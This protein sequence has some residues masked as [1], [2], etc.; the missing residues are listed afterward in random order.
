MATKRIFVVFVLPVI[1]SVIF[2]S[3]VMYGILEKPDRELNMWRI[4]STDEISTHSND[5]SKIQIIGLSS[6][7]STSDPV[8][9]QVNVADSSFSCGDIYITIHSSNTNEVIVQNGFFS[10]CFNANNGILPIDDAFS[11]VIDTAGSYKITA[12]MI[13]K[14]LENISTSEVFT[15]K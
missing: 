4:S 13:S 1:F 12:D 6:Q 2:G 10:Q 5:D 7:Y 11:T 8:E 3:I 14:N 9:I 15:V